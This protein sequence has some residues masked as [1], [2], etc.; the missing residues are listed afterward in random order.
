M[1]SLIRKLYHKSG[2]SRLLTH[3]YYY[4]SGICNQRKLYSEA[5]KAIRK[6]EVEF[7]SLSEKKK[8]MKD[9]LKMYRLYGFEF[10][11]YFLFDFADKTMNER[12]SFV[13]DW[14]HI[15]YSEKMNR[16]KS[17]F[18]NKWN[19]YCKYKEFFNRD[20]VYCDDEGKKE[21]FISFANKNG[22][23]IIKPVAKSCGKGI[24]IVHDGYKDGL[25]ETLMKECDGKFIA[26]ELIRQSQEMGKFHPDSV[27]TV[28]IPTYRLD[29][30]VLILHPFMRMGQNG[31]CVDNGGAGGL[32]CPIDMETTGIIAAFDEIGHR[33][34]VHPDTGEPIVGFQIPRWDELIQ[35]SKRLADITPENRYTGWDF[36]LTD[37]GWVIVEANYYGQFVGWQI[38]SEGGFRTEINDIMH[39]MGLKY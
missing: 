32:I 2:H 31:N 19:T 22:S 8:C 36:A 29:D 24:K 33:Y 7:P 10:A 16:K 20:A 9:M 3:F 4:V 25:F 30:E 23:F 37:A 13:A 35:L 27:N 26:E 21:Q 34:Q 6:F 15:G 5:E 39:R 18:A 14:E 1:K 28:R 38:H 17:V 11:E 12:L